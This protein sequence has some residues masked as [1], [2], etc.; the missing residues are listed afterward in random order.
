[1]VDYKMN[2]MH[3]ARQSVQVT[4]FKPNDKAQYEKQR[5]NDLVN[6]AIKDQV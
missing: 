1:M 3:T 5:E 2:Q 6:Q 4:P